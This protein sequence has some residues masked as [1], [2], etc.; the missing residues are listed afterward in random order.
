M[1]NVSLQAGQLR[2]LVTIQ[3]PPTSAGTR[4]QSS[5]SWSTV[6]AN[7]PA[8]IENLTG[9]EAERARQ[10]A[11]TATHQVTLRYRSGV[12]TQQR[13]LFGSR[14]LNIEHVNN[15]DE[16]NRVLVLLCKEGG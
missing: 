11:P 7:V 16:R 8:K 2:H 4:G 9:R 12:T 15:L 5:G 13:L 6:E 14:E 3:T 1:A 10:I